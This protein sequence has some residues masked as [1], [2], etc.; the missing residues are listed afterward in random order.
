MQYELEVITESD[1]KIRKIMSVPLWNTN[2]VFDDIASLKKYLIDFVEL[3]CSM[4]V[5]L[6][7]LNSAAMNTWIDFQ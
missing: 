7:L 5:A 1:I 2:Q 6:D 4:N 3:P